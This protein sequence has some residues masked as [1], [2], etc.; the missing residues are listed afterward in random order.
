MKRNQNIDNHTHFKAYNLTMPGAWPW[1]GGTT[2]FLIKNY[3]LRGHCFKTAFPK[4]VKPGKMHETINT[5][6][7]EIIWN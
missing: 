7:G 3:R 6:W 1:D 5:L 4:H 2:H